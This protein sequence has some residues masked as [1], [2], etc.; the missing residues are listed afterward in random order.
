[1]AET[2]YAPRIGPLVGIAL[3][4]LGV[5]LVFVQLFPVMV[6][7]DGYARLVDPRVLVKSVWLPG[8]QSTLAALSLFTSDPAAFRYLTLVQGVAAAVGAAWLAARTFGPGAGWVAG[9]AVAVLPTFVLSSTALYQ[10]SLFFALALLSLALLPERRGVGLLLLGLACLVRYEGWLLAAF[11]ASWAVAR[12]DWRSAMLAFAGPVAW[13]LWARGV[14]PLGTDSLHL[15]VSLDRLAERVT[16]VATQVA[17]GGGVLLLFAALAGVIVGGRRAW[18]IGLV[19]AAHLAWLAFLD[20]YSS[21]D[22]PRQI[23]IALL[24]LALLAGAA[25]GRLPGRWHIVTAVALLLPSVG[26]WPTREGYGGTAPL[27]A[28]VGESVRDRLAPDHRLLVLSE[29]LRAW[30][31]AMSDECLAVKAYARQGVDVVCD[32]DPDAGSLVGVSIIV[33]ISAFA[34]WRPLH[35]AADAGLGADWV[36]AN[37]SGQLTVWTRGDEAPLAGL[38]PVPPDRACRSGLPARLR[39]EGLLLDGALVK[40]EPG[41]IALYGNGTISWT[42]D[43]TGTLRLWTCGTPAE[44]RLPRLTVGEVALTA[45]AGVQAQEVGPVRAGDPVVIVYSDDMVDA[46]GRDRNL[47]VAGIEVV[48]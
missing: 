41:R 39:P 30:P 6:Y 33:R 8:Y 40:R 43:R 25:V 23:H 27:A 11:V 3:V 14:S 9:L 32:S 31:D 2:A 20:P 5:R 21:P 13:I 28:L 48:P 19:G 45:T 15:G 16:I 22:H 47:F 26:A 36:E 12:R 38:P 42:A 24:V 35:E 18:A 44:G 17:S 46:G 29:G 7:G 10:E 1:M 4:A 34:S 37:I